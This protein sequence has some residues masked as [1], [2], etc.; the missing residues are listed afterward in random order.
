MPSYGHQPGDAE[1]PISF[2][3]LFGLVTQQRGK[4]QREKESQF[5]KIRKTQDDPLPSINWASIF[6]TLLSKI[7]SQ[8]VLQTQ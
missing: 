6:D 8:L 1:F 3:P 7:L 4:T 5:F 2:A